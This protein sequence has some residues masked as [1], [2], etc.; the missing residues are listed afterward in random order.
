ML[1][2]TAAAGAYFWSDIQ[3]LIAL[4]GMTTS[5]LFLVVAYILA[6]V[7]T[8]F[9]Y[10]IFYNWKAKE[11]FERYLLAQSISLSWSDALNPNNEEYNVAIRKYLVVNDNTKL[12]NIFDDEESRSLRLLCDMV[13]NVG[14]GAPQAEFEA[15]VAMVLPPRFSICKPFIIGVGCSWPITLIWLLISRVVKQLIER[16]VSLFGNTFDKISKLVFGKF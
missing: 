2:S 10:W 1:L 4:H 9:I 12:R 3:Q 5:I 6:G 14:R 15:A 16:I 11:R 7:V 13:P 8:A